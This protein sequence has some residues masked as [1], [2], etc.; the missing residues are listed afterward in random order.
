M[1]WA[2]GLSLGSP[3]TRL[4]GQAGRTQTCLVAM[5]NTGMLCC[6]KE[7]PAPKI[8]STISSWSRSHCPVPPFQCYRRTSMMTDDKRTPAR[9]CQGGA[10]ALVARFLFKR[11]PKSGH[12]V[13]TPFQRSPPG[14][15]SVPFLDQL[16]YGDRG[17]EG[18]AQGPWVKGPAGYQPGSL[19]PPQLS[20]LFLHGRSRSLAK[21]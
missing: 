10:E 19:R 15:Y 7:A 8:L 2:G 18:L 16:T 12:S 6:Q 21:G 3:H 5:F 11:S 20:A 13:K 4:W 17:S 14:H 9:F 1:V